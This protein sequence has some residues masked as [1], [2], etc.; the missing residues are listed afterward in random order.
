MSWKAIVAAQKK[1]SRVPST[2]GPSSRSVS[3]KN[4]STSSLESLFV[5]PRE[6]DKVE[7]EKEYGELEPEGEISDGDEDE[8]PAFKEQRSCSAVERAFADVLE[9]G[10]ED[11]DAAWMDRYEPGGIENMA[12]MDDVSEDSDD[13]EDKYMEKSK[14]YM[15]FITPGHA[16]G[17]RD[18][19][20]PNETLSPIFYTGSHVIQANADSA[21]VGSNGTDIYTGCTVCTSDSSLSGI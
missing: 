13:N 8:V 9:S 4:E 20:D 11:E 17:L 5:D 14:A 7:E 6:H 3:P 16:R 19:V 12:F 21:S 10:M 18:D 2:I 1:Q 15:E